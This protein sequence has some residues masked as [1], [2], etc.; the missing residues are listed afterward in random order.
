MAGLFFIF[1]VCIMRALG[2]LPPERGMAAMQS[3][4][5]TILNPIFLTVFSGTALV[6]LVAGVMALLK[7][8]MPGSR[9]MFVG[10]LCYLIG[11]I[12]I[13]AAVNVPMNDAL[14][15]AKPESTQGAEL[16][17]KYL[18]NWTAWNHVRT[19][20]SIAATALF[21]LALRN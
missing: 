2:Q 8:Q 3:I 13:T 5:V 4:N 17:A 11:V 15:A 9:L 12:V 10:A 7:W 14:A 1:S 21:A 18:V 16:W 6:C 20:A 19:I